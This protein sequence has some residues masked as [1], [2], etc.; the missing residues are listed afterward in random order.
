MARILISDAR[1]DTRTMTIR[2]LERL[3]HEPL[4]VGLPAPG[5]LTDVDLVLVDPRGPVG[6]IV[7]QAAMIVNP[8][9][10]LVCVSVTPPPPEL[11]KLGVS[12]AAALVKPFASELLAA[13]IDE[14]LARRGADRAPDALDV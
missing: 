12:F 4:E 3:G 10:P 13:T 1:A 6:A 11:E 2:M 5:Q 14:V 8:D 9:L 7:C